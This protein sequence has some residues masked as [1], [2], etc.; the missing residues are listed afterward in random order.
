MFPLRTPHT[1][2]YTPEPVFAKGGRAV[3]SGRKQGRYLNNLV[4][5][6]V[7]TILG[8]NPA[9]PQYA[10][11]S[12]TQGDYRTLLWSALDPIES[13]AAPGEGGGPR[14]PPLFSREMGISV[15][16][17]LATATGQTPRTVAH[18]HG[19]P[20]DLLLERDR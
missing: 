9:S 5:G 3:V 11:V 2:T 14:T 20:A 15:L 19:I 8:D 10:E 17:A 13:D 18:A 6:E 12:N 4:V 1:D 16:Y 7:V